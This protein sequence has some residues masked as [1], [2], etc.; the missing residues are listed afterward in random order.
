MNVLATFSLLK[1][2]PRVWMYFFLC[3]YNIISCSSCLFFSERRAAHY[4][5]EVADAMSYCH[6]K[7]VIHRDIKPENLLIGH[8][9][10][11]RMSALETTC[12]LLRI[13]FSWSSPVAVS[14]CFQDFPCS[15]CLSGIECLFRSLL[16]SRFDWTACRR[17]GRRAMAGKEHEWILWVHA[18]TKVA[19][20]FALKIP[21]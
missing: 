13:C 1:L 8:N 12:F 9:G 2:F 6:T 19:T 3:V 16:V 20:I 15:C 11:V 18:V 5:R 4:V 17:R 10:E 21:F 14:P 7:H